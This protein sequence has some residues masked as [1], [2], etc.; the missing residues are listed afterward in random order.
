MLLSNENVYFLI[1]K[2]KMVGFN[3]ISGS[4]CHVATH[5]CP[6][7]TGYYYFNNVCVRKCAHNF[8]AGYTSNCLDYETY[9]DVG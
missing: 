3:T 8:N 1:D 7:S 9:N 2:D 4:S 5:K 6:T